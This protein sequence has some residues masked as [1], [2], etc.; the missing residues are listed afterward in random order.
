MKL[1][2]L[3]GL[4]RTWLREFQDA[5]S[6]DMVLQVYL[7]SLP[8]VHLDDEYRSVWVGWMMEMAASRYHQLKLPTET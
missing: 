7:E 2:E 4:R 1:A 8:A 5:S 3:E 6:A